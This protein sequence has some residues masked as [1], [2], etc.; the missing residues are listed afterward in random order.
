MQMS[1]YSYV[2]SYPVA[3]QPA[4]PWKFFTPCPPRQ[5]GS[6]EVAFYR[7]RTIV[8]WDRCKF[9]RKAK[10]MDGVTKSEWD[11]VDEAIRRMLRKRR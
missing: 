10:K 6:A 4:G 11:D 1:E 8:G 7:L 9:P 3:R 2:R 5:G